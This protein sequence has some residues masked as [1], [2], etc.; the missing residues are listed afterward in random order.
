MLWARR[1]LCLLG[2]M[3]NPMTHRTDAQPAGA[4]PAVLIAEDS[5]DVLE[6]LRLL[7]KAEGY[8]TRGASS[9]RAALVALEDRSF[10]LLLLDLNYE[11]DTTSGAEG[12][13]LLAGVRT[14]DPLLPVVVMTAWGS[15]ELAVEAMQ[16]GARDFIQKPWE[17][18]RLLAVLR[19]QIEEGR[20]ARRRPGDQRREMEKLGELQ[21]GL[22]P[23]SIPQLPRMRIVA[24]SRPAGEVGGDYFD[25]LPSTADRAGLCIADVVG[26]GIPAAL[27][28]ANLQAA[29]KAFSAEDVA[30][31][32]LVSRVNRII[33]HNF[34][35]GRFISFFYAW[36]DARA[37]TLAWSN[38]GHNPPLLVRASGEV[39]RLETGGP[40]LGEFPD[41][42]F[43]EGR[44]ALAP[45]DRLL[46]YTDGLTEAANGA[47][48]EFGEERVIALLREKRRMDAAAL[49]RELLAAVAAHAAGMLHDD[50]TWLLVAVE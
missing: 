37:R 19:T 40:V 21:R 5:A 6:A 8:E 50:T 39:E 9:P 11:R 15:I 28:M 33:C 49:Q 45:G 41:W 47:G 2:M 36:L 12:L 42:R 23:R 26:K 22:M 27:Q 24:V 17:N 29:V 46:L 25:V 16:R 31:S 20:A 34:A 13:D 7:L 38:A 10:D 30:P 48:E 1:V 14:I 3:T 4:P 44:A 18:E 32:S 35:A 43:D